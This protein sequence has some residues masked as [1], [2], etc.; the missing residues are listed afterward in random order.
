VGAGARDDPH[1]P[2][3]VRVIL[4]EPAS[5]EEPVPAPGS[6]V[7]EANVDD[8]D[9]RAWPG[10]L[11][12]LLAAGADDA[13]LAPI[14]MKKGRP[15]HTLSV[16]CSTLL[17][18]SL[19]ER[20]FALTPTLGVREHP[21]T[22]HMLDRTWR[23]VA[24]G[25]AGVRI[26]VGHAAGVIVTATPEYADVVAAAHAAG[27]AERDLLAAAIAAAEAAGLRPGAALAGGEVT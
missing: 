17:A 26:K 8:L 23:T 15:A 14:L 25:P 3:V 4:L 1:R 20:I 22:K 5:D 6:V 13:W 12:A 7:V 2:N 19:R 18:E 27:R 21:V 9:P 11:D 10:I 16:L 24:V